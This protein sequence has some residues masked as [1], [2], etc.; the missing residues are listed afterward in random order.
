MNELT[1]DNIKKMQRDAEYRMREMQRK[2]ERAV[3]GNDMPPVPNFVRINQQTNNKGNH[4]NQTPPQDLNKE[5]NVRFA[6]Q[7]KPQGLLGKLKGFDLLKIFN[8]NNLKIDNDI[9]IILALIFLLSTE[10]TDEL[11]LIALLYIML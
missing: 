2:A 9:L 4:T 1:Q 8:F 3:S 10:D 11:L 5:H 7:K 6:E